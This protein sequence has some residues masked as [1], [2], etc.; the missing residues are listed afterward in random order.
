MDGLHYQDW[1]ALVPYIS[2]DSGKARN[3]LFSSSGP[4]PWLC[5]LPGM[6]FLQRLAWLVFLVI[7]VQLKDHLFQEVFLIIHSKE[8]LWARLSTSFCFTFF[9]ALPVV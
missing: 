6:L 2:Q 9:V 5:P 8:A 3:F 4:F 1:T 7:E